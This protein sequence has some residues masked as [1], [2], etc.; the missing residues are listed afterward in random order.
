MFDKYTISFISNSIFGL[1][2][3]KICTREN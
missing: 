3:A 2:L 1:K